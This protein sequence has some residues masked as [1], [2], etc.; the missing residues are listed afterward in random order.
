MFK[1]L[2]SIPISMVQTLYGR[3]EDLRKILSWAE[4]G[5]KT[6]SARLITGEG[7]TGKTRLAATVAQILRDKGWTAGFLDR[8]SDLFDF[9]VSEKGLF[10]ILD[11]PEEHPERAATLLRELADRKTAPY[12][13]RVAF[14]S[15]RPFAE[16]E[17]EATIL[18][19]R[20][21]RHEIAAPAP[22]SNDDGMRLIEEAARNLAEH[23]KMPEP[24]L[25]GAERWLAASPTHRFPLYATA[26]AIHAVLSPREAFGLAGAELLKQLALRERE[27]VQ[28]TSRMLGLGDEGLER[29]LALGV[30]ADG[31][32]EST[33]AALA[34]M[35]I[36]DSS[37][38]DIAA[39]LAQSP[40]WK[41]GR[42][43]RLEPAAPAAAFFDGAL[44]SSSFPKGRSALSDW[45]FIALQENAATFGNRLGRILYDLHTLRRA[46]VGPHP[47]DERLVQMVMDKP[48]RAASFAR[49]ASGPISV[50][51]ANFALHVALIL[52]EGAAEPTAKASYFNNAAT[53]LAFLGRLEEARAAGRKAVNLFGELERRRPQAFTYPLAASL[54]N[55]ANVLFQ[56][57]RWEEARAAG[58]KARD[59]YRELARARPQAFTACLANSLNNLAKGLSKPGHLEEAR[60]TAQEAVDLSRELARARPEVETSG[61]ATSLNTLA[62]VL[63]QLR[64]WEEALA[65]AQEAVDLFRESARARPEA[66]TSELAMSLNTLANVLSELGRWE[67]ALAAAQE[68]VDLYRELARARPE[69]E[70]SNLAS[71][72]NTLAN[73][74]SALGRREEALATAQE[75][76][77]QKSRPKPASLD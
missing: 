66:E 26:A 4:S 28:M 42:L 55:L 33:V 25:R 1:R 30:L 40:W 6:P 48:D 54:N 47:L 8:K 51:A 60:A 46:D 53:H 70:T 5:S 39:A 3:D 29:L 67:E 59:L 36:F 75:T 37:L 14:L 72:L 24:D 23:T 20:F 45:M 63:F 2:S 18:Q 69:A 64:H 31:L 50:W 10:L 65:A 77:R 21:G 7:G 49:V 34:K 56:L 74:L 13:I 35:G 38:I 73:V 19:G 62:N 22:L 52:A 16:W 58:R 32:S 11:Y 9:D 76:A 71:S 68:A 61:L 17:R 41:G 12:P 43:S 57:G 27:R 15:R 44:F